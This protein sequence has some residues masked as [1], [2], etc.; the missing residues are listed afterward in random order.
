M[1]TRVGYSGIS[2]EWE[3]GAFRAP[4]PSWGSGTEV[5]EGA[6]VESGRVKDTL[7][8]EEVFGQRCSRSGLR[9]CQILRS[10]WTRQVGTRENGRHYP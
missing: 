7:L 10:L 3:P 4:A 1:R 2:A 6:S 8:F 9:D 5:G